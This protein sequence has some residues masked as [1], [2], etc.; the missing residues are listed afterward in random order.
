MAEVLGMVV[1]QVKQMSETELLQ[2]LK[3]LLLFGIQAVNW[4]VLNLRLRIDLPFCLLIASHP[5]LF[6]VLNNLALHV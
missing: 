1:S 6:N 2:T 5:L 3:Q 4:C